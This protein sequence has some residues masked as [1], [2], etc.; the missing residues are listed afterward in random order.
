MIIVAALPPG[1][2]PRASATV[3]RPPSDRTLSV[4]LNV[5]GGWPGSLVASPSYV[6]SPTSRWSHWCS[7]CG[8]MFIRV[9]CGPVV[10]RPGAEARERRTGV[11]RF[12][13]VVDHRIDLTPPIGSEHPRFPPFIGGAFGGPPHPLLFYRESREQ[14]VAAGVKSRGRAA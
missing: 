4:P 10:D 11:T 1:V 13:E 6:H 3:H 8:S 14:F 5:S 9:S 7:F 2:S 12:P